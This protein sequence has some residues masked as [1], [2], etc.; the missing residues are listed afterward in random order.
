[1]DIRHFPEQVTDVLGYLGAGLD[2]GHPFASVHAGPGQGT[3]PEVWLLGSHTESAYLAAMMGLPFSYAHFFG[4]DVGNGPSIVA[5]YRRHFRPSASL[6]E[7]KVG[8]GVHVLCAETEAEAKRLASSR[9]LAKLKT[10]LGQRGGVPPVEAALAYRYRPEELAYI[11]DFSRAYVDG[12]PPQVK[13]GLEALAEQYQTP[14][15]SLVTICY[16]FAERVRSYELVAEACGLKPPTR[17]DTSSAEPV[18]SHPLEWAH[19]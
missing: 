2:A 10:A 8:V 13:A 4:S 12:N 16:G 7:P 3:M 9:N 14:Y 17:S 19:Q 6:A 1:R 18:A 5:G 11:A 15:V